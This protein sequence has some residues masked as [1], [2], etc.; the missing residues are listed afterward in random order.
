MQTSN[1]DIY[2]VGDAVEVKNLV[3]GKPALIPLA[4]P[5]NKQARI[6][7]DNIVR[8]NCRIYRGTIG[9]SIA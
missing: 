9:T 5:A 1:A 3:T 6:A 2:A 4:G 7:A 8:G